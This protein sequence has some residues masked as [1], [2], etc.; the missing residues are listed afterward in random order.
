M[1]LRGWRCPRGEER[2][3]QVR[4][5]DDEPKVLFHIQLRVLCLL[6]IRGGLGKPAGVLRKGQG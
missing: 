6:D 4:R 2:R 5:T 3:E 1:R